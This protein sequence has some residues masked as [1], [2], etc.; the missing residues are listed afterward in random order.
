MHMIYGMS[1]IKC[2]TCFAKALLWIKLKLRGIAMYLD[3]N[4]TYPLRPSCKDLIRELLK[5]DFRNPVTVYGGG[6]Y[7]K[8]RLDRAKKN[9]ADVLSTDPDTIFW[10]SGATESNNII[11][12]GFKGPV[13]VCA[14]EHESVYLARKN[15]AICP[16]H[17][18]GLIDLDSLDQLLI[19]FPGALVSCAPAHHETGIIQDE[20]IYKLIKK[21]KAFLHA[22][23]TQIVGKMPLPDADA[24]SLS[25]HKMGGLM[26]CGALMSKIPFASLMH[27]GSQQKF[28]RPGTEN[29]FGILTFDQALKEA[30]NTDWSKIKRPEEYL[31]NPLV[32]GQEMKR[33]PNVSL[34]LMPGVSSEKQVIGLDL[35]GME[36]SSGSAC[37]SGRFRESRSLSA[38]NVAYRDCALRISVGPEPIDM[39]PFAKAWNKIKQKNLEKAA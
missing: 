27:G 31:D 28:L 24:I 6:R 19:E 15:G 20:N 26:G 16:V 34:V 14:T 35:D 4:A 38:M 11:L 12:K 29:I 33:L 13:I 30:L 39:E 37:S 32:V 23:C 7:T 22:D 5:E 8:G 9:L 17:K 10:T 3:Y 36:L 25:G 21:H 1:L 2:F 18:N